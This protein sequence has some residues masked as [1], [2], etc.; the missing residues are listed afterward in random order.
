HTRCYR[1]WSSDVCSSDLAVDEHRRGRV[2]QQIRWPA[3]GDALEPL[4]DILAGVLG[5]GLEVAA[6]LLH[7]D[8]SPVH[9]PIGAEQPQL[10]VERSEERRGGKQCSSWST[11]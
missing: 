7:Y 9:V 10:G 4:R 2:S 11:R 6:Q 5:G 1:D 8:V 3:E